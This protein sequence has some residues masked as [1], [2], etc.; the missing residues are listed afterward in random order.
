MN[1]HDRLVDELKRAVAHWTGV[2]ARCAQAGVLV[3]YDEDHEALKQLHE[4]AKALLDH[5]T[6]QAWMGGRG[7]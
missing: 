2:M 1:E 5:R 4:A 6:V 3:T 7:A